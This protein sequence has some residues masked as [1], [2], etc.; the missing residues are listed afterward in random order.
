MCSERE[1][2]W[3]ESH[4]LSTV[5]DYLRTSNR[6]RERRRESSSWMFNLSPNRIGPPQDGSHIRNSSAPVQNVLLNRARENVSHGQYRL[7]CGVLRGFVSSTHWKHLTRQV[8]F[9]VILK[10]AS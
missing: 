10:D 7:H 3:T 6:A 8:G 9:F 4:I 2:L 5:Q 1:R